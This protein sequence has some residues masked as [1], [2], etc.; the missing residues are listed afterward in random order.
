MGLRITLFQSN[1]HS[2]SFLSKT[3]ESLK[4][5]LQSNHDCNL[6]LIDLTTLTILPCQGC[7]QCWTKTPGSC[8]LND[9]G[10]VITNAYMNSDIVIFLS[11]IRFG[12]Y[13]AL[14]KNIFDRMIPMILP[15]F[16]QHHGE[17][18]HKKRYETYPS[19]ISIGLLKDHD[20]QQE[21][22]FKELLN[23]NT[24]NFY[25]PKTALVILSEKDQDISYKLSTGLQQVIGGFR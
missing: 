3:V 4:C 20:E 11:R 5:I 10:N 15:F 9:D 17:T 25:P 18:H 19:I 22:I 24:L 2:D 1:N 23:R 8:I 21:H 6:N 7:F 13:D 16:C 12:G 14:M